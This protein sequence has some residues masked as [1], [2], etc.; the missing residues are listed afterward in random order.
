MFAFQRQEE[1]GYMYIGTEELEASKQ[2]LQ[3][4][5]SFRRISFPR[6]SLP[7][8]TY[9]DKKAPRYCWKLIIQAWQ[10]CI[11]SGMVTVA[12][13]VDCTSIHGSE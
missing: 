11:P 10:H 12:T 13:A 3:R 7:R 9:K 6:Q 4:L 5:H 8:N 2:E 1:Q